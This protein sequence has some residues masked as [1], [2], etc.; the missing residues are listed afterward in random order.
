MFY[1]FSELWFWL[2]HDLFL[3]RYRVSTS[4]LARQLPSLMLFQE[5]QELMRRPMVDNK[6][7]AVS[8]T[9]SE[10]R[11][12]RYKHIEQVLR[13]WCQLVH[14][15]ISRRTSSESLT[16]MSSS[17]NP[18]RWTKVK[19]WRKSS[20][21]TLSQRRAAT[22]SS[23]KPKSRSSPQKARKTSKEK[24]RRLHE[25]S[26]FLAM[27]YILQKSRVLWNVE[28]KIGWTPARCHLFT[29]ENNDPVNCTMFPWSIWVLGRVVAAMIWGHSITFIT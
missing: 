20:R 17:K 4:P 14:Y 21:T 10:V 7:R 13:H 23:L 16:W 22:S 18:R 15:L 29:W 12:V 5:G 24:R 27:P 6:A 25:V 19:L 9:F 1:R 3:H 11:L 8:W 2:S 26:P 28:R